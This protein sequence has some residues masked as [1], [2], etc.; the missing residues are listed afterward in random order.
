[1]TKI[2]NFIGF[3]NLF[4]KTYLEFFFCFVLT[5]FFFFLFLI[6]LLTLKSVQTKLCR[7]NIGNKLGLE[8]HKQSMSV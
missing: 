6:T 3:P 8:L 5:H 4:S 2:N 1:M 7:E